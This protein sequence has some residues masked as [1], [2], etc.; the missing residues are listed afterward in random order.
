MELR[1]SKRLVKNTQ[2]KKR[3]IGKLFQDNIDL[4]NKAFGKTKLLH[5]A[6]ICQLYIRYND[7]F[8]YNMYNVREEVIYD[9]RLREFLVGA[10]HNKEKFDKEYIE[11]FGVTKKEEKRFLFYINKTIHFIEKYLNKKTQFLYKTCLNDDVIGY[12]L[13]FL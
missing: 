1:R 3:I 10:I 12:I 7:N 2:D 8:K 11:K 9:T 4:F 5:Y 13:S 6:N